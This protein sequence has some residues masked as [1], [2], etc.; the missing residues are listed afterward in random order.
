ML[1]KHFYSYVNGIVRVNNLRHYNILCVFLLDLGSFTNLVISIYV[2]KIQVIKLAHIGY[3][4]L[5]AF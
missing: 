2:L 4:K 5:T 1:T 3:S